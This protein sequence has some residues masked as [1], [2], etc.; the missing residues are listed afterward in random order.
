MKLLLDTLELLRFRISD[1]KK[2][3]TIEKAEAQ[4]RLY[5]N[6]SKPNRLTD[7]HSLLFSR[8]SYRDLR[9]RHKRISD[10]VS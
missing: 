3:V 10:L 2:S 8:G 7:D 9:S 1:R 4:R 5:S 6:M